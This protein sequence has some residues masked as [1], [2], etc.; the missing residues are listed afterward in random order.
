MDVGAELA[1]T[2]L[3]AEEKR[4]FVNPG[5]NRTTYRQHVNMSNKL[6]ATSYY[7]RKYTDEL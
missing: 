1:K 6:K 2:C 5:R 3:N 7:W 4:K